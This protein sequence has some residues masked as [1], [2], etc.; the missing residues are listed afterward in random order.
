MDE[1][2]LRFVREKTTLQLEQDLNGEVLRE[3]TNLMGSAAFKVLNAIGLHFEV[4]WNEALGFECMTQFV[5]R[6][7]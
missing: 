5:A 4:E 6:Q 3:K 2:A 1:A 7:S